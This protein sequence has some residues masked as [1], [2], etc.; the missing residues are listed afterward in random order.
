MSEQ[1]KLNR[2]ARKKYQE[3]LARLGVTVDAQATSTSGRW[4]IVLGSHLHKGLPCFVVLAIRAVDMFVDVHRFATQDAEEAVTY[5][6]AR[7]MA[8]KAARRFYEDLVVKMQSKS[9]GEE[10]DEGSGL[11]V[12][13]PDGTRTDYVN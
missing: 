7:D 8:Y 10:G 9:Q 4:K 11:E 1:R 12:I 5:D 6:E 13:A 3:L 2:D